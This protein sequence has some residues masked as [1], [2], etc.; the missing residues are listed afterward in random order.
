MI[1]V[2]VP[3]PTRIGQEIALLHVEG[4]AF[5]DTLR[6]FALDDESYARLR[7]PMGHG[8]LPRLKHLDIELESVCRGAF[9]RAAKADNPP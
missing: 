2:L 9:V 4:F 6:A 7:V 3:G 1:D 8:M 5:D